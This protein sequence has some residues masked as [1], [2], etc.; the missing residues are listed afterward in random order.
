MWTL[1]QGS[2]AGDFECRG[3]Y[4]NGFMLLMREYLEEPTDT[5]GD[6]EQKSKDAHPDICDHA[7]HDERESKSKHQRKYSWP[8]EL[9]G[10]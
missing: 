3:S 9:N 6:T 1:H 10:V 5:A 2:G 8:W 4:R 7:R